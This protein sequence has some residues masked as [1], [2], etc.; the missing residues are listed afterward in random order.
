MWGLI[1]GLL[2]FATVDEPP[3]QIM[4]IEEDWE[5]VLIEPEQS[6]D[7]PQFHTVISPYGHI[8]GYYVQIRWNH[9]ED[10]NFYSGG[11]Q[12]EVWSGEDSLGYK[13]FREDPFSTVAETVSWTQTM[14]T[15]GTSLIFLVKNG[16]S[17]TWGN[18]GG[19]ETRLAGSVSVPNLNDY[20]PAVSVENSWISFGANRVQM[21]RIVEIR[22]Y[23]AGG[24]LL[25][26]DTSPYVVYEDPDN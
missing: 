17:S 15:T 19:S 26:K 6:V 8:D 21:L 7:A 25:F 4:R 2:V 16:L 10:T 9:R 23:D 24:N 14:R 1:V 13:S 11:L 3:P 22:A 12:L 18:F 5:C 20:S